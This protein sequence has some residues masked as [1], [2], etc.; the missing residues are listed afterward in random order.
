MPG[1]SVVMCISRFSSVG[2]GSSNTA[3][4]EPFLPVLTVS[5]SQSTN[6][7]PKAAV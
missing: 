6:V 2:V 3:L 5:A 1:S 7:V 4:D